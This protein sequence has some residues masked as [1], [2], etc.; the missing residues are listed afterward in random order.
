MFD[1]DNNFNLINLSFLITCLLNNVWILYIYIV[2]FQSLLGVK[3]LKPSM[4]SN[5]LLS[6]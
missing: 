1:Q 5:E 4:Y 3:G 2:T 6:E